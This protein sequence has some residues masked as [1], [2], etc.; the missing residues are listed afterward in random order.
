[1]ITYSVQFE[2]GSVDDLPTSIE[3]HADA[4]VYVR[5]TYPTLTTAKCD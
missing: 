5:L 1:M 3:S 2:D 4:I